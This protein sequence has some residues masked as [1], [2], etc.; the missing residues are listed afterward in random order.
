MKT[1]KKTIIPILLFCFLFVGCNKNQS[2]PGIYD[3]NG[4]TIDVNDQRPDIYNYVDMEN[5]RERGKNFGYVRHTKSLTT[6]RNSPQN[7]SIYINREQVA[8]MISRLV[9]TLPDVEDCATL[10]TDEEVLVVYVANTPNRSETINQVKQIAMS[11]VPRY[12][13]VYV[14]DDENLRKDIENFANLTS[15]STDIHKALER[16]IRLMIEATPQGKTT[17]EDENHR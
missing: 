2:H 1:L 16:T 5:A 4:N 3:K 11:A 9:L 15:D 6:D 12:Y 14:T 13:H 10:V 8:D 17:N 7:K